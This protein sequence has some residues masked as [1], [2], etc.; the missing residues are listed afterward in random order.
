VIGEL[1]LVGRAVLAA[2][3]GYRIDL[4]VS[5]IPA[6]RPRVRPGQAVAE[7]ICRTTSAES[8]SN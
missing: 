8:L 7:L 6:I 3:R 2:L 1:D 4:G 5:G